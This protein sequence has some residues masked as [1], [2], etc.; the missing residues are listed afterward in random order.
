MVTL[1]QVKLLESKVGKAIDY[2]TRVTEENN[3]LKGKLESSRKRID[4]LEGLVNRFKDD[5]N[6]IEEG[7]VAALD[8]LN[9][10]EDLVGGAL[11]DKKADSKGSKAEPS[12]MKSAEAAASKPAPE[13]AASPETAEE[14][15]MKIPDAFTVAEAPAEEKPEE[16]DIF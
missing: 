10:F 13:T 5:Q 4:E 6:R 8:R 12:L 7:I 3:L 1:E 9:Q 11:D 15:E 16:L 14:T 2:V